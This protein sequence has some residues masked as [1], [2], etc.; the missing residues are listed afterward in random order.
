MIQN[1]P[2]L[3]TGGFESPFI[4]NCS[5]LYLN[6]NSLFDVV[7]AEKKQ[8]YISFFINPMLNAYVFRFCWLAL[9]RCSIRSLTALNS[10]IDPTLC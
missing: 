10:W 8:T 9:L 5:F 6:F 4:N 7:K 3:E 2:P 1:S